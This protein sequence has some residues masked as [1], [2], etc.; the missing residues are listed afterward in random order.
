[1]AMQFPWMTPGINPGASMSPSPG[2]GIPAVG[3][4]PAAPSAPSVPPGMWQQILSRLNTP[5]GQAAAASLLES[6]GWSQMPV[7]GGQALGRSMMAGQQA[8]AAAERSALETALINKQLKEEPKDDPPVMIMDPVTGKPKYARRSEAYGQQPFMD[9]KEDSTPSNLKEWDAFNKMSPEDQKRYLEMKRN[10][11]SWMV[12]DIGGVPT[13]VNRSTM[14]TRPLSSLEQEAGAASR[15]SWEKTAAEMRAKLGTEAQFDLG[16]VEQNVTQ[17]LGD[18]Q[19]LRNHEGLPYITGWA[20]KLPIVPDTPMAA[21]D[22]LAKQVQGQTFL[23]AY[24]TLKGGGQI[25]EAEGAKAESAIARLARAQ[26]TED[27][28]AALDDLSSVLEAGLERARQKA[29]RQGPGSQPSPQ[30]TL[31]PSSNDPLGL[32]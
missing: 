24:Q 10:T 21:A 5:Q 30:P 6:G 12:T 31:Q 19:K 11:Q 4:S 29:G 18:I 23:Q 3:G 25:T 32:R 17:A 22:A 1:M 20:S 9:P 7:T 13:G 2:F 16:R 26:S 15:M 8:K 14:E 27:Y 28:Q